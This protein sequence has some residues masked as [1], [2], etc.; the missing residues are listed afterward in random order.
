M[1]EWTWIPIDCLRSDFTQQTVNGIT[2]CYS[3]IMTEGDTEVWEIINLTA[4]A[5]PI[6]LHLAQ[7]QLMNR[8]SFDV[9]KYL[10]TYDAAFQGG[11]YVASSGPPMDYN[12]S[13][14]SGSKYGGNPD[15]TPFLNGPI[16]QS[17]AYENGWKDT[18]MSLPGTVTRIVVRWAP[19]DLSKSSLAAELYYP[20][21]PSNSRDYG[22]VWH[23][24]IIDHEDN[25]MMRPDFLTLNPAAPAAIDR[26]F[27]FGFEY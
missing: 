27:R 8:Q 2:T 23:C 12:P 17:Y 13:V 18:I 21:D 22:Y 7:F 5:H 3:E 9:A 20:F 10:A 19:T 15:V 1:A 24:H 14:A 26:P 11:V 25:E 16:T 6:H 4:D